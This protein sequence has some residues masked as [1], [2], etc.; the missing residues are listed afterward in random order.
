MRLYITEGGNLALRGINAD[1]VDLSK[2]SRKHLVNQLIK[3][4]AALNRAYYSKYKDPLWRDV[5]L[6]DNQIMSGSSKQLFNTVNITDNAFATVKPK[7]GDIDVMV[8]SNKK[9]KLLE[10]FTQIVDKKIGQQYFWEID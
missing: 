1:T 10:L 6:E 4:F 9:A 7:V 5:D 8:D 2:V 3:L